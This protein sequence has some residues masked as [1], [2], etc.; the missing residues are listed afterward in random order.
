MKARLLFVIGLLALLCL[1]VG[2]VLADGGPHGDYTP[3]TDSCAG[4]HRA[5]TALGPRL[6]VQTSTY[7]FCVSCHGSTGT[8]ANTNVDDGFYLSSR[9]DPPGG[10][11]DDVGATNT[12]DGASLLGGGFTFY[13]GITVTSSHDPTGATPAAWGNGGIRGDSST[14]LV[15]GNLTCD[16]CHDPHGSSNYRAI[17]EVI[18]GNAVTVAQVDEG[19]AKDYDTE[20][21]GAG[22]SS[23]CAACH[24]AYHQTTAGSGSD[25]GM[26]ASGG[27]THRIDM[28]WD[29]ATDTDVNIGMG[30]ANPETTGLGG[31]T[32]PLAQTSVT[33]ADTNNTVV[34]MTCHLPHGTAAAMTGFADPAYDPP[35][36]LGPIPA[37][38]SSLLRLDNRGVCQVCHQKN[39]GVPHGSYTATTDACAEC[40]GR[41]HTALNPR[42]INYTPASIVIVKEAVPAD[43]T[44]FAFASSIPGAASFGLDD[45][46]PVNNDD[47]ITDTLIFDGI[48]PGV[49]TVTEQLPS[50]DWVL[51]DIQCVD[52]TTDTSGDTGTRTATINLA[53]GEVV[54]CTFRNALTGTILLQEGTLL[55]VGSHDG[56]GI[57]VKRVVVG[58]PVIRATIDDLASPGSPVTADFDPALVQRIVIYGLTGDDNIR[59]HATLRRTPSQ[60][61][62]GPGG[63]ILIGSYGVDA[64]VGGPGDD[65]LRGRSGRNILIGGSDRDQLVGNSQQDVLVGDVWDDEG[66]RAA[67]G[68][69]AAEWSKAAKYSVRVG[70][71]SAGG[72]LNGSYVLNST[73]VTSDGVKDTS[74]GLG[75]L[76]WFLASG[77]DVTDQVPPEILTPI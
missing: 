59:V 68:S 71:L 28:P 38:D 15:A 42:L 18:N 33:I 17:K 67:I 62:G 77:S 32:L 44:D 46:E 1:P 9:D 10:A 65:L 39:G 2:V 29:G 49:Y 75:Q 4:C 34:C 64:L 7:D 25:A 37:S 61:Y 3:T 51:W 30:S 74:Q 48:G 56:D 58:S 57:L 12:P 50:S 22:M 63:D 45:L 55:V 40:H 52:P 21:W 35:G 31:F 72:G 5:K 19:A 16:S 8:G 70:N 69:I 13:Q 6:L 54:T 43:G 73:T 27:Y 11:G 76:D 47:G 60:L 20:Q 53:E 24:E 36:P 14:D 41:A 66:N 23:I 26:V